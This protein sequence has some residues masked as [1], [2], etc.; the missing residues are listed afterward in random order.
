MGKD[1]RFEVYFLQDSRHGGPAML[2]EL[3]RLL[4]QRLGDNY[5]LEEIDVKADPE[6]AEVNRVVAIPT[7]IRRRPLP[8]CRYLGAIDATKL[9]CLLE[10]PTQELQ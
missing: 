8:E 3:R 6:R 5:E 2:Q 10:V 7:L 9:D 4:Q 1:W